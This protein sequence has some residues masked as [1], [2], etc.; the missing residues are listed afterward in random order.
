ML[1]SN[2]TVEGDKNFVD[3]FPRKIS[4]DPNAWPRDRPKNLTFHL[5]KEGT[6]AVSI[7]GHLSRALGIHNR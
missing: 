5:C 3:V 4:E 7:F 6:D 2:T 1:D